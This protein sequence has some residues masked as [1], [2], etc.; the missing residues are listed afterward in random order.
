MDSE[1]YF[2]FRR[3]GNDFAF[4]GEKAPLEL[5]LMKNDQGLFFQLRYDVFVLFD[6][7]DLKKIADTLEELLR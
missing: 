3:P 1:T 6:T 7:G 4:R 5:T 2:L